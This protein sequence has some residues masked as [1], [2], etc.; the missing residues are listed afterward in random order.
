MTPRKT[1]IGELLGEYERRPVKLPE[2]QRSY[3]WEKTQ[4]ATFWGDLKAF[5]DR[6]DL[7]P[8]DA[9]YFLGPVVVM[10]SKTE[11]TVLDGQQRLATATIFLAVLRTL[12]RELHAATPLSDLDYC[13]RDIQRE[14]IEKKDTKPLGYS[15]TLSE[16]DEPYFLQAIKSDPS[17][18]PKPALRSHVLIKKAF[19]F[20]EAEMKLLVQGKSPQVQ[21]QELG[22]LRNAL[23]KGMSLVAIV[24]ADEQDAYEIFEALNDR[25][26]RLSVPDLVINLLLKRCASSAERQT[27]RQTWNSMIQQMGQRDVARFLR[28]F[29][30]SQYGD[31]KAKGLYSEIKEHLTHKKLTSIDFAQGCM[32]ACEDYLK[33]LSVDKSLPKES[34][35]DVEGLVRHLSVQNS[36]PL[37]LSGYR[38]LT[39]SDF[40]KLVKATVSLYVRHTLIGN[41]NPLE[42]ETGLYDIAREI[43]AQAGSKVA[44]NKVLKSVKDKFKKLNPADKLVEQ[45]FEE[46]ILSRTEATWFMVQLA[47]AQQSKT[48]EIGMGKANVEHIFPQNAGSDW[49]N[50]AELEPFTW[51]VGNLTILGKRINGKAQNKPYAEKCKEHYSIS[52][53]VMTKELLKIPTWDE[54]SIRVRAKKMA[55]TANQI[56]K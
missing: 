49:P 38:H 27:V 22:S 30:L 25:G 6:Y 9:S 7:S 24:V 37:L 31:L 45:Q 34:Q 4:V 11:I 52:E 44:S 53:I 3:S 41:Q 10:E 18:G 36:L 19:D 33:L 23:T 1:S 40:T 15:L 47:N 8:V 20:F 2:F 13:A 32:E 43:H 55:A 51:H 21:A 26:L 12:A 42:L 5:R 56:W 46:L 14:L 54:A 50:R 17:S 48:K 16:M 29:W 35:M 39:D 28:H